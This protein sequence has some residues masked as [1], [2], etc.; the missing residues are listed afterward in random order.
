MRGGMRNQAAGLNPIE[1]IPPEQ[2]YV[3]LLAVCL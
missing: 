1:Y 2:T 3:V